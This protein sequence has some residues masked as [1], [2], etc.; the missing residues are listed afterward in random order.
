MAGCPAAIVAEA[1]EPV[2][3]DSAKPVPVPVSGMMCGEP[4]SLA[5][6]T[7][8]PEIFPKVDGANVTP[9]VQFM[10]GA[11]LPRH[12]LV[13]RKSAVLLSEVLPNCRVAEP[14]LVIVTVCGA[15]EVP[16]A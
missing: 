7:A 9:N 10:F 12:V 8:D 1:E 2:A 14:V 4:P 5:W 16:M 13:N 11:R 6:T 15:L 3:G